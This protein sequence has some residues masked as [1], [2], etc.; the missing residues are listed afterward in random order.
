MRMVSFVLDV[1]KGPPPSSPY[2]LGRYDP[3][4]AREYFDTRGDTLVKRGV[5]VVVL[6][7]KFGISLLN[8][9]LR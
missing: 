3:R 1:G 7:T 8:D 4:A 6:S 5:E 9:Y 2:P